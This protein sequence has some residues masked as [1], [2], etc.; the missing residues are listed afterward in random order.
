MDFKI[1]IH[2]RDKDILYKIKIYFCAGVLSKHG[3]RLSNIAL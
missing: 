2:L 3:K 1:T